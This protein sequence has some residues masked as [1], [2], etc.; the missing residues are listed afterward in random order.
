MTAVG[1]GLGL[2]LLTGGPFSASAQDLS[3]AVTATLQNGMVNSLVWA[4]DTL[5]LTVTG[6]SVPADATAVALN[7]TVTDTHLAASY[8]TVYPAGGAL[9]LASNLNWAPGQTRA[10]LVVVPVGL[11]GQVSLYD[12]AGSTDVVVDLEGYFSP[13]VAGSTAGEYSPLTPARITDTRQGSR[14][15]NAGRTLGP[16]GT[17]N[18]QVTGVGGVPVSNVAAAVLEVTATNTTASSFLTVY[19]A[20]NSPPTA[21]NLN[22]TAGQTVANCVIVPVGSNGQIAVYNSRGNADVAVD[23]S[24]YFSA[25]AGA[26][27]NPSL[28]VPIA[29]TRVLD[30]RAGSG[31]AGAGETLGAGSS[32]SQQ[33]A[34][35]HGI[36][37][38][39]TAVVANVTATNTTASSYL[40]LYPGPA[41]PLASTLNWTAGQTIANLGLPT[42]SPSGQ[43]SAYNA[44]GQADLVMDVSGWFAPAS[45]GLGDAYSP[46]APSRILDTRSTPILQ[47]HPGSYLVVNQGHGYP[48]SAALQAALAFPNNS[49]L[50]PGC[51]A[52]WAAGNFCGVDG[53]PGQCAYWVELNWDGLGEGGTPASGPGAVGLVGNGDNVA[54]SAIQRG[55]A[56]AGSIATIAVGDL[57]SWPPGDG[58]YD[59]L[60]GHAAIVV[61]V[62]P[63]NGT[64]IVS[65]MNYTDANW[66]IDYRVVGVGNPDVPT[67]AV[68]LPSPVP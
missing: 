40:S 44:F 25:A 36:G 13:P 54:T 39:A 2:A 20:G 41:R 15:A 22:W 29:P 61:E 64:Y 43:L 53:F 57:V 62:D 4:G 17:L 34:G 18:I 60:F 1:L 46:L 16:E 14:E 50:I 45:A 68:P 49:G 7:V 11:N 47:A 52:Q 38:G 67:I 33:L 59:P 10:N 5:N 56:T 48:G 32:L 35:V 12:A 37:S 42:L 3:P 65:E 26:P 31:Q 51:D 21:S 63:G 27:P 30:T 9:P 8:L 19:P 23:V 6:G 24:G 58:Q 66:E 55:F 28:F